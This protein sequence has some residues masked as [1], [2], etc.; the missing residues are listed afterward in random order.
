VALLL[1]GAGCR[2]EALAS[3]ARI[4]DA[5]TCR[6]FVETFPARCER[7]AGA[8]S[9]QRVPYFPEQVA[10]AFEGVTH[11][12]LAGAREPVAMF[13]WAGAR[14]DLLPQ[15]IER[16][17]LADAGD[18]V[19][20]ALATQARESLDVTTVICAN[21]AY[22][23]LQIEMLRA[24]SGA[25]GPA[26]RALTELADPAP[27]WVKLASGMGVPAERVTDAESLVRALDRALAEPGP[28]LVE[29]I[30]T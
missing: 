12:V 25:G 24:G 3:A 5:T 4:A 19:A 30:L 26:A 7:G 1:G 10:Q 22:R 11:V 28:R 23:I 13:G 29:A 8:P 16:V 15:G 6:L 2:P 18:D 27:D 20:S 14:R 21:R 9:L 17:S